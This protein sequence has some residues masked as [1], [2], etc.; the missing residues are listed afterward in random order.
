[1]SGFWNRI[2][3]KKPEN[4]EPEYD[5]LTGGT[6]SA[7]DKKVLAK[8]QA[9][10][11]SR[12]INECLALGSMS[13]SSL[14]FILSTSNSKEEL[15]N[16]ST[17]LSNLLVATVD[18]TLPEILRILKSALA[19]GD[20]TRLA[21]AIATINFACQHQFANHMKPRMKEILMREIRTSNGE[22]NSVLNTLLESV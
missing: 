13:I 10:M 21:S 14:L 5:D 9:Q 17:T 15:V 8:V 19:A 7:P 2:F 11:A 6:P 3:G 20:N 12:N 22:Y 1:M 18:R 16:V 4:R